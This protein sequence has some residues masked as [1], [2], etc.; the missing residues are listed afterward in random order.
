[1]WSSAEWVKFNAKSLVLC[2]NERVPII[3]Y[4][5]RKIYHVLYHIQRDVYASFNYLNGGLEL[6]LNIKSMQSLILFSLKYSALSL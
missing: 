3:Q 5:C 6:Q 2:N 4:I 1:M